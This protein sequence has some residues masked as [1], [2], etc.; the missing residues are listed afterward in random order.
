[1]PEEKTTRELMYETSRDVKWICRTL[2]RMEEQA[3]DHEERLRDLEGWRERKIGEEQRACR[4]GA[5]AGGLVGGIVAMLVRL[6]GF[7]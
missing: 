2:Q 6:L 5:G 7:G 3:G 1:M 4:I